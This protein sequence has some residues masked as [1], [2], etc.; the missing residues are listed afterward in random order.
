MGE[1]DRRPAYPRCPPIHSQ[2]PEENPD[3]SLS[4]EAR[5][6]QNSKSIS[7]PSYI[8]LTYLPK[9]KIIIMKCKLELKC[10][11]INYCR[12]KPLKQSYRI[13]FRLKINLRSQPYRASFGAVL[14]TSD[15][16]FPPTR[17]FNNA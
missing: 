13:H 15:S 8:Q 17:V 10:I 6:A 4:T 11:A 12:Q 7:L 16:F 3:R 1:L 5:S 9:R 14:R 2:R